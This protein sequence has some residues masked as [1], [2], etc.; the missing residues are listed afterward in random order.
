MRGCREQNELLQCTDHS[1]EPVGATSTDG[2]ARLPRFGQHLT[3]RT[4]ES[5]KNG[6]NGSRHG[7][8]RG[9]DEQLVAYG[10]QSSRRPV[11]RYARDTVDKHVSV[12][13]L[14]RNVAELRRLD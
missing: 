13:R 12:P 4:S 10:V 14:H 5:D 3:V 9:T 1:N 6:R 8:S 7:Q 2:F 11:E